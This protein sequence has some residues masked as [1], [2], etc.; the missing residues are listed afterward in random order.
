P[1]FGEGRAFLGSDNVTTNGAGT[2]EFT[3]SFSGSVPSGG[4]VS[5]TATDE[6][7]ST[8][9][10]SN[11]L[12]PGGAKATAI[13]ADDHPAQNTG[14]FFVHCGTVH[15]PVAVAITPNS[16]TSSQA[17]FSYSFDPSPLCD[18]GHIEFFGTDGFQTT[19]LQDTG[20]TVAAPDKPPVASI[21]HPDDDET[22]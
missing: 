12:Q 2:V 8:S 21:R 6:G 18:G 19:G 13:V 14:D 22:F 20:K 10:F 15:F 7:G 9:E 3:E 4:C 1:G 16:T 17:S 5:A 11:C